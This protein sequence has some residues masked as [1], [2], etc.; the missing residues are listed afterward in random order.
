[1]LL[2]EEII[3]ILEGEDCPVSDVDLAK[4]LKLNENVMMARV[5]LEESKKKKFELFQSYL[6]SLVED[7]LLKYNKKTGEYSL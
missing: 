4:D 3:N 2:S 6:E 7:N 5:G 1:M